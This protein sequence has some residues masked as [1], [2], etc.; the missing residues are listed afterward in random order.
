MVGLPDESPKFCFDRDELSTVDFNVDAFVVKYKREVGLEKLRDDLDLFLRVLQSNMVDLINRDFADFLNLSTNLVGF[1]KSITTLK[2]PLTVM[3]MDIMKINEILCAQRK[4]IEEKLHEQEIIRKRRQVIQSIIDV[5]K[6]IQQLNELDDAINLSKID[7]SEMIE[8]AIVQFSFISIQLDKCDQNEPTIESLKSVIENLRRVFEKRLTA[9]FMDGY[10]E[11]NMSLL[12]DSLKGLASI[13]LQT[14]AEQTFANEIVKPYIEKNV[15]NVLIQSNDISLA[16]SKTIDFIKTECKAMLYV[17]ERINHDCG[18]HFDFVVNSIFPELTQCLEQSSQNFFSA[19]DPDIFHERYLSWLKFISLLES[20]LSKL[21]KQNL[22]NSKAYQDFSSRWDVIVYYQ[23]RFLEISNSIENILLNQPFILNNEQNSPYKTLIT[24]TIF[25]SIDRCWQPNIFLEPLSHEFWKLTLQCIVRFRIWIETFNAKTMDM[26]FLVNLYV[27]LQVFSNKIKTLFQEI[28][29]S[30]RLI[31][32]TSISSNIAIELTN[33]LDEMLSGLMNKSRMDLKN[34]IIQ[35]LI[36]RCNETLHSV[37]EIPRMYRKTNR[38][39]PTKPSNCILATF[40]H[41][42]TFS[43]DYNGTLLSSDECQEFL[44]I[45]MEEITKRYYDLCSEILSSV[46]KMEESMQRLKR[47][48]ESSR[49][50]SNQSQN[51]TTSASVTLTDDNKIRKQIQN[52][53]TAFTTELEKL[54]IHIESSNK[55]TIL[56]EESQ[57]Q[58]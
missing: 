44:T 52:D 36:D 7:I 45:T 37:Q 6:S 2:N 16:F 22:K 8:R 57:V 47:V 49:T 31:S 20:D 24:S 26:K 48:R 39:A 25:Q 3:K 56:N 38:E 27:D 42:Q 4:Q 13:S 35:Q 54:N 12:A 46:R 32:L 11:P 21:S 58:I 19:A 53:V 14:V 30:Q 17:I 9:A 10:R 1:D 34:L 40:R 5:Q 43:D 23:I 41:L 28:I 18:S 50:P 33:V 55:L 15:R 51:M 29:L